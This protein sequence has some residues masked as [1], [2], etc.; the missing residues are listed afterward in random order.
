MSSTRNHSLRDTS[1]SQF[2][3]PTSSSVGRNQSVDLPEDVQN[4]FNEIFAPAIIERAGCIRAWNTPNVN[5][6]HD[7]WTKVIQK[8]N[9]WRTSIGE[10]AVD[11][12]NDIFIK[13]NLQSDNQRKEYVAK[14]I[15]GDYWVRPY[16]FANISEQGNGQVQR[17]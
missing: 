3:S 17:T 11:A 9:N 12:L 15:N 1:H 8:L 6:L 10:A 16:Y 13:Q 4:A 14:Q 5:Q 7:I 2:G